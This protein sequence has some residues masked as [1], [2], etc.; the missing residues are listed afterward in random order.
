MVF[1]HFRDVRAPLTLFLL[2]FLALY[3]LKPNFLFEG[4]HRRPF[5][6]GYTRDFEKKTLFDLTVVTILLSTLCA[7][8]L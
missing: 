1:E 6:V 3:S 7:N 5:G 8:L 2:S 4:K